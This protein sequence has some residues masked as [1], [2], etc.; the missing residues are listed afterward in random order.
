M[1]FTERGSVSLRAKLLREDGDDLLVRFAV[2]DTGIGIVPEEL[3]RLFQ[4]FE[5]ADATTTRRFG[6][7]GLGLAIT[8]RLAA[9]MGGE[10]GAESRPGQGSTFWFTARLQRGHGVLPAS[11]PQHGGDARRAT[12]P[13]PTAVPRVLLAEDNEVN[14]EL[15]LVLLHGVGLAVDEAVNWPGGGGAG[16]R[17]RPYALVLMDLQM[18]VMG[19]IAA[20]KAIRA[21][22]GRQR[23]PVIALT[24][25][26]IRRGPAGLHGP[27]A[28]T[29]SSPSR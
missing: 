1:K 25:N 20:T 16:R 26:A 13:A 21:L 6:G 22:P 29:I 12:S 4:A 14:R 8:Q 15:A 5:Q 19:G 7:T 11:P 23:V 27:P 28:W 17:A 18:P 3:P 10:C 9:L 24:A 2:E